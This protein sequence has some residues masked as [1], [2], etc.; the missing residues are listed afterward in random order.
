VVS[1]PAWWLASDQPWAACLP[2]PVPVGLGQSSEGPVG[3]P[4]DGGADPPPILVPPRR[5]QGGPSGVNG[6]TAC[7]LGSPNTPSSRAVRPEARVRSLQQVYP[8][9]GGGKGVRVPRG[10][11][12]SGVGSPA[13]RGDVSP[14]ARQASQPAYPRILGRRVERGRRWMERILTPPGRQPRIRGR[15]R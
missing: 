2:V 5:C 8:S 4:T 7:L 1:V 3:V 9:G 15:K 6:E 12:S 10:V 14:P 11:V 13:G